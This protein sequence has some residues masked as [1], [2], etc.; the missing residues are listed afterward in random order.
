[1]VSAYYFYF[2]NWSVHQCTCTAD[3]MLDRANT[4]VTLLVALA[5]VH[6]HYCSCAD[7]WSLHAHGCFCAH[8]PKGPALAPALAVPPLC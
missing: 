3:T 1:M 8:W 5:V 7:A 6:V 2:N 4:L